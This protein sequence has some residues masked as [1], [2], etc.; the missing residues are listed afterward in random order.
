M[1]T[2]VWLCVTWPA[3]C[4]GRRAGDLRGR[5]AG[6][7]TS[8]DGARLP[9][10]VLSVARERTAGAR[11]L[12]G[13]PGHVPL[14]A[15]S[16]P[17]AYEVR[18]ALPGFEE[19]VVPAVVVRAGEE[20]PLD[21][22]LDV[23]GLQRDGERRGRGPARDARGVGAARDA[24]R[25][26][27]RGPGLEGRTVAVAQGRDR[28]RGRAAR[29][30]EPRPERADRRPARLRRVPEPHGPGRLPRGLRGGGPGRGRQGAFRREEPGRARR[31]HQ[32]GDPQAGD[33]VARDAQP[34]RGLLRLRQPLAHRRPRRRAALGPRRVL[35]AP[36]RPVRGRRRPPLHRAR[37]L[38]A[39]EPG[40]PGLLDRHRLGPR[41]LGARRGPPARR[42]LHPPGLGGRALPVPADGRP[43]GRHRP[44][45]T[46]ATRRPASARGRRACARR[47][48][49]RRSTT[50]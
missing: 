47:A 36:G 18:A 10:V 19:R 24:G 21:L 14:A 4:S 8:R 9:G 26:H 49:S 38:P 34:R 50:G 30:A 35:G 48:T 17:G 37:Q 7:V 1:K 12:H 43:V 41:R 15:S 22:S 16:P 2:S 42:R 25:R 44:R 5:L 27:R 11:G 32:R 3:A 46:C 33:G 23:A 28:E 13:E 20:T 39:R 29:P 31:H 45:R 40:R 6:S